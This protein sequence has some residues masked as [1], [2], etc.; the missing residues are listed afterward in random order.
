MPWMRV[1]SGRRL[2]SFIGRDG[3]ESAMLFDL[4][5]AA[6]GSQGVAVD[7]FLGAGSAP[8]GP[9]RLST[10]PEGSTHFAWGATVPYLF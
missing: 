8:N 7:L 3:G 9:V 1:H 2:I 4:V 10:A 5:V 6:A